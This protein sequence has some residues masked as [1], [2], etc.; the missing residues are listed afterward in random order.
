MFATVR[1][2]SPSIVS[3][4]PILVKADQ[5]GPGAGARRLQVRVLDFILS[6]DSVEWFQ[7][8]E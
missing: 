6:V 2:E 4:G 5:V 8:G 7:A 1:P 3:E